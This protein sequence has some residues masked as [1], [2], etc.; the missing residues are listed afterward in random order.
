MVR[1]GFVVAFLIAV[2]LTYTALYWTSL[3]IIP[4]PLITYWASVNTTGLRPILN[5]QMFIIWLTSPFNAY[6]SLIL[7]YPSWLYFIATVVLPTVVLALILMPVPRLCREGMAGCE[8]VGRLFLTHSFTLAIATSYITSLVTWFTLGKPGIGTSIYTVFMLAS[9][10]YV[11]LYQTATLL[12]LPWP[13]K[14]LLLKLA[15]M[16][17]LLFAVIVVGTIYSIYKFLPPT[18]P[19][20]IGLVPTVTTLTGYHATRHKAKAR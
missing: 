15:R 13:L 14:R 20:I 16:V 5:Y 9:A 8:T 3:A 7:H 18:P 17:L 12:K 2:L 11:T 1:F 19:H 10:A 4:K 6:E